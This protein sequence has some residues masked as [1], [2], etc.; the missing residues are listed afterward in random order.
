LDEVNI[1]GLV[2]QVNTAFNILGEVS[3]TV[4]G[5]KSYLLPILMWDIVSRQQ[6][7]GGR[8]LDSVGTENRLSRI[9]TCRLAFNKSVTWKIVTLCI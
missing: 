7:E 8:Q 3:T 5:G 2:Y 6:S 1:F 9:C 4:V